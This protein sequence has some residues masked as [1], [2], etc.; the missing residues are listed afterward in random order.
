LWLRSEKKEKLAMLFSRTNKTRK[1]RNISRIR[2]AIVEAIE[3]RLLLTATNTAVVPGV[4]IQNTGPSG[5]FMAVGFGTGASG[6][7]S[8]SNWGFVQVP[9]GAF[10]PT[11]TVNTS[12]GGVNSLSISL[13]NTATT[14]SFAPIAGDFDVF[15]LPDNDTGTGGPNPIASSSLIYPGG[16]SSTNTG[17]SALGSTFGTFDATSLNTTSANFAGTF[18]ITSSLPSGYS[19]FTLTSLSAT[20]QSIIAS[21]INTYNAGAGA[22]NTPI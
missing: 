6:S 8:F 12:G 4:A 11:Y 17:L 22:T 3:S 18:S 9:I 19:T 5:T 16:K 2:P 14:G 15:V 20:V 10:N 21:D 7:R 1:P 13:F